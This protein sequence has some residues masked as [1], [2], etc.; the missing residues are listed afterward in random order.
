M[1]DELYY[2]LRD[3]IES[4]QIFCSRNYNS[5][6]PTVILRLSAKLTEVE[7]AVFLNGSNFDLQLSRAKNRID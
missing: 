1:S 3:I 6:E 5:K 4:R 2:V 7:Q